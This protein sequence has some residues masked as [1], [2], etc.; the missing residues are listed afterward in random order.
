MEG[1]DYVS[2]M[3][4]KLPLGRIIQ[5]TKR[6][7]PGDA[8]SLER[9]DPNKTRTSTSKRHG[10]QSLLSS[11]LVRF[12][13]FSAFMVTYVHFLATH[14]RTLS[15]YFRCQVRKRMPK[16]FEV[17]TGIHWSLSLW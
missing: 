2:E 5:Y 1:S 3:K 17:Q 4:Q 16:K 9:V 11:A 8:V 14:S 10:F 15:K 12:H 6:N 7:R 13:M